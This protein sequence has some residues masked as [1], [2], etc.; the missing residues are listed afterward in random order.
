MLASSCFKLKKISIHSGGYTLHVFF[1]QDVMNPYKI[2]YNKGKRLLEMLTEIH[3]TSYK[4]IPITVSHESWSLI[5][6]C[7]YH[8][9]PTST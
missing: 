7:S 4:D 5:V 6:A 1:A 9:N 3:L 8:Y 2:F